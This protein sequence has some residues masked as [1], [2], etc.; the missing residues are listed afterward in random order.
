MCADT[1]YPDI[2]L[3]LFDPLD[4]HGLPRTLCL[5]RSSNLGEHWNTT[6]CPYDNGPIRVHAPAAHTH[7]HPSFSPDGGKVV[8]TSDWSGHAQVYEVSV[9]HGEPSPMSGVSG[10][11]GGCGGNRA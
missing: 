4:G 3:Q 5:S 11:G 2:G 10:D 9:P 7:P 8:F 6:Y 1:T